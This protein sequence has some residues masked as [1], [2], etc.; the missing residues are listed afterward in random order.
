MSK[1]KVAINGFGRIGRLTFK[2]LSQNKDI[3]IVAINDLTQ[4]Q[5]LAHL[6]K[7]DT[8]HGGYPGDLKVENENL[9]INGQSIKIYAEPKPENLPWKSLNVDVVLEATGRFLSS[10][11]A[12]AHIHAGAKKVILSA[13]AKGNDIKFIVLGVNDH[14][15]ESSDQILSNSSCTTNCLAPMVKVLDE[16]AGIEEGFMATVHAYTADQNLVDAPHKDLRRARAAACNI[17]PTST[18]AAKAVGKVIPHLEGKLTGNAYRVPIPNGSLTDFTCSLKRAVTTEEVNLAFK[19]AAGNS[20][21]GILQYNEEPIVSSDII[22]NSHSCIFEAPLT[23]S[24]SKMVKVVG[25]YDNE[26]GYS[27]RTA[28]LIALVGKLN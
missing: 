4:P 20:L 24:G 6:L 23:L 3:E 19:K 22:G 21:K 18:G 11:T 7:Y 13:P 26:A 2:F 28:D 15:I 27:A 16:L 17:I 14:I 9:I 10:D 5:T 25:W 1:V 12:N 8:V